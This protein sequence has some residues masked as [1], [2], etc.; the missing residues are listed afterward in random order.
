MRL[1][2][3]RSI[4]HNGAQYGPGDTL[5][6]SPAHAASLLATKA[7]EEAQEPLQAPPQKTAGRKKR[8]TKKR[9]ESK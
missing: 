9:G 3:L 8:S 4:R 5:D 1:T 2:A 7:A 6:V